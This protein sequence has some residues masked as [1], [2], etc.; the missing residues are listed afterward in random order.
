M[1]CAVP[2][3]FGKCR[4]VNTIFIDYITNIFYYQVR[5]ARF[6]T[7]TSKR[8]RKSAPRV[9]TRGAPW[10][11]TKIIYFPAMLMPGTSTGGA[12]NAVTEA[13]M[14]NFNL[15]PTAVIPRSSS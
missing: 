14:P 10:G 5:N 8:I 13:G 4:S 2:H 7:E 6:L 3:F 12:A 15:L 9:L 1:L 11:Y